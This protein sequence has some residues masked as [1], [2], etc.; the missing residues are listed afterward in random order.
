MVAWGRR[1]R[2]T[3]LIVVKSEEAKQ[4]AVRL[5]RQ[6]FVA[7]RRSHAPR[8]PLTVTRPFV[9]LTLVFLHTWVLLRHSL[10][11]YVRSVKSR[12]FLSVK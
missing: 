6:S 2:I 5:H 8:L 12:P 1:G 3:L 4:A 7:F 10:A 11:L 9:L